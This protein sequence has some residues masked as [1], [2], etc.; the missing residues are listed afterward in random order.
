MEVMISLEALLNTYRTAQRN[1]PEEHNPQF[2]LLD[3]FKLLSGFIIDTIRFFLFCHRK[4][5][6]HLPKERNPASRVL[7]LALY[8]HVR[9]FLKVNKFFKKL[10]II[11]DAK[12]AS[13]LLLNKHQVS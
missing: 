5:T 13:F 11:S 1:N 7:C 3:N 6:Y 2:H 10:T 12:D 9:A 4:L 8:K